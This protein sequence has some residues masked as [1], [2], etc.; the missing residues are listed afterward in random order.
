M[1]DHNPDAVKVT[2][3]ACGASY[4]QRL[5]EEARWSGALYDAAIPRKC[6]VC[7]AASIT[8]TSAP[9]DERIR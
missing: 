8:V 5:P 4:I 1:G 6:G 9:V 2:C 7:G 3:R